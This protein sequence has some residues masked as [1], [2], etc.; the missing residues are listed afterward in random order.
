M[1]LK[2]LAQVDALL[3]SKR[4]SLKALTAPFIDAQGDPME[5]FPLAESKTARE[6]IATLTVEY[7]GLMEAKQIVQ[8]THDELKAQAASTTQYQYGGDA[9]TSGDSGSTK[10]IKLPAQA[11]KYRG[12]SFKK[13]VGGVARPD[14]EAAFKAGMWLI[15][16]LS[17]DAGAV[18]FCKDFGMA[19][20]REVNTSKSSGGSEYKVGLENVNTSG[21]FLTPEV[22]D[23]AIIDLREKFG[24]FEPNA[25][26]SMMTSDTKDVPRRTGGLTAYFVGEDQTITDST[27]GWDRVKLIAKKIACLAKYSSE[28]NEDAIIDI[29]NDLAEE[30]AYAFA[31]LQDDCG[32]NGDGTSTYGGIIGLS[33]RM[34][35]LDATVANRAGTVVATGTGYA[36]SYGSIVLSDFNAL[37]AKLPKYAR[38]NDAAWYCNQA[39]YDGVMEKLLVAAGGV[40][41]AQ[42]QMGS[43]QGVYGDE[44]RFL[45]FP[46]RTVQKMSANPAINQ[47][48]CYFGSLRLAALYGNRRQT[49]IAM[50]EHAGFA[51]DELQIRGTNRF[52]INVHDIGNASA[53]ASLRVPGPICGLI[54]A[55][56]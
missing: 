13:Y 11:M 50:S 39:F 33:Q 15:A 29:A 41:V 12:Q 5:G 4:E 44:P 20:E 48:A 25:K 28:L 6:E 22:L 16:A 43:N 55:A 3:K 19:L 10:V 23:T 52:D 27:K 56:S 49:T 37:K 17:G 26:M 40:T 7:D 8:A 54:T 2:T 14:P 36:S 34:V 9:D 21:G 45:G 24:M 32:F 51:Q 1:Q 42:I 47:Y 31:S 35:L 46:V 53:T 18:R 38:D 30:I